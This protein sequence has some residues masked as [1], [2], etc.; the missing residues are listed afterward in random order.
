MCSH[1]GR[2]APGSKDRVGRKRSRE[3]GSRAKAP[4]VFLKSAILL[5]FRFLFLVLGEVDLM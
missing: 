5:F 2:W 4:E 3:K 1:L